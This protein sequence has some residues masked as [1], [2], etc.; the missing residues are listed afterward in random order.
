[1]RHFSAAVRCDGAMSVSYF[2]RYRMEFDLRVSQI[3]AGIRAA[4]VS[5]AGMAI[6]NC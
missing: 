4:R 6:R 3:D 5:A 2:K 1:M